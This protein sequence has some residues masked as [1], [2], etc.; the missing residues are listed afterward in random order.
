[1]RAFPFSPILP[2]SLSSPLLRNSNLELQCDCPFKF[3]RPQELRL[4]SLTCRLALDFNLGTSPQDVFPLYRAPPSSSPRFVISI[5]QLL[6]VFSRPCAIQTECM[7]LIF[8]L[9]PFRFVFRAPIS[10]EESTTLDESVRG[11]F[12][13]Y[14]TPPPFLYGTPPP[15]WP[16]SP[17]SRFRHRPSLSPDILGIRFL[18]E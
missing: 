15:P 18:F 9:L 11:S 10:G 7:L 16:G 3:E 13:L 2:P 8:S 5:C 4:F 6:P 17:L 12:L 1:V 14:L